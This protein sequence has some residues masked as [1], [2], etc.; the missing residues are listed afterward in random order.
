MPSAGIIAAEK[1]LAAAHAQVEQAEAN[2]VKAQDDL[3]RY[4]LLVDKQEVSEQIYD[5]ALAAAKASTATVAA[6][7]ANESAAQQC[8]AAGQEP[9]GASGG[10]PPR[11]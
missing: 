7:R 6:A 11:R 3:K 1:Q 8:G 4:K 5:Q 2:D 10:E 9:P